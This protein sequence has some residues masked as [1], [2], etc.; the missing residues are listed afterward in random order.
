M[1][2]VSLHSCPHPDPQ[3]LGVCYLAWLR[4]TKVADGMKIVNQLMLN[5]KITLDDQVEPM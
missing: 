2:I 5:R 1:V 3:N 4:G